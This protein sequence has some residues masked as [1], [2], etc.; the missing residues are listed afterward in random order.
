MGRGDLDTAPQREGRVQTQGEGA[1]LQGMLRGPR[2]TKPAGA[3]RCEGTHFCCL[4][5]QSMVL[6]TAAPAN[7][8]KLI[9]SHSLSPS[10][11][12]LYPVEQKRI[13]SQKEAELAG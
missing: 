11:F 2:G 7:R 12:L 4:T 13:T 9:P 10:L 8:F 6:V 1:H 3:V 5:T